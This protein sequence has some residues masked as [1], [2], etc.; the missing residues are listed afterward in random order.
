M[1]KPR[2]QRAFNSLTAAEI[3]QIAEW[4]RNDTYDVVLARVRRPRAEGGYGLDISRSPLARLHGKTNIVRKINERL[5]TGE[6]LTVSALDAINAAEAPAA[7]DVHDAIMTA[8][9]ALA[10]DGDNTASEL[11]TLQT[12]A[13][14]PARAELRAE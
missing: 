2:I 1:K 4:L 5:A 9:H 13:D 8:T 14:F 10:Q 11:R 12:L 3:D 7:E 6:Q